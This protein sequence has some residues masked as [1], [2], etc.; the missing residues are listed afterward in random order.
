[1][2]KNKNREDVNWFYKREK[3][4][5]REREKIKQQTKIEREEKKNLTFEIERERLLFLH[6]IKI[7]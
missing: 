2:S 5:V 4:E 6:S 3:I 1:M 7:T